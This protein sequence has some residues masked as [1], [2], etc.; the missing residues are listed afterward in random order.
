MAGSVNK[1]ILVGNLGKDPEVRNSQS[2]A[3][4]VSFPLATSD[5]WND[6]A[7]GERRERTEWHRIVI[8]NER[9]A[10]VAERFLRKGRK[11]YL[12]GSLQ[13]RKWTDQGGQERFTTEVIIDRF[14]GELTLL[15]SRQ[16]G[17]GGS[18]SYGGGSSSY[19]GSSG[20][21]SSYGGYNNGGSGNDYGSGSAAPS[22]LPAPQR[23]GNAPGG[24]DAS[25][26]SDLD[27]EIPF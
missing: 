21:S 15:D 17:E 22:R 19:G 4:I 12:E 16:D 18:G 24:W 6:R 8:F 10:D 9:L 13:T 26:S 3:K 20:G 5:T 1:V 14:R 27:D 11:V 23:G 2:G 25:G 7:S